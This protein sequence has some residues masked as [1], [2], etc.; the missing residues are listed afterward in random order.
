MCFLFAALVL[1]QSDEALRPTWIDYSSH[2][3]VCTFVLFWSLHSKLREMP[4]HSKDTGESGCMMDFYERYWRP[5]GEVLVGMEREGME[6]DTGHLK[7]MEVKAREQQHNATEYFRKWAEQRVADA[8]FMNVASDSQIQQLLFAGAKK[9]RRIDMEPDEPDEY[10]PEERLFKVP[11]VEGVIEDGKKVAKKTRN[12]VLRGLGVTIP[13]EQYTTKGAPA[14]TQA[15]LAGLAGKIKFDLDQTFVES[16]DSDSEEE[17]EEEEGVGEGISDLGLDLSPDLALPLWEDSGAV[18]SD[19]TTVALDGDLDVDGGVASDLSEEQSQAPP[20][21]PPLPSPV[22]IAEATEEHV[23]MYGKAYGA[24]G[25]GEEGKEACRALSALV[26]VG[27]INSLLT[28][29]LLP[30]QGSDIRGPA[31]R[32]HCSLN[33]SGSPTMGSHDSRQA[34]GPSRSSHTIARA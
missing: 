28:N 12:I 15:V 32:V 30:L 1:G 21:P 20:P 33:I 24:F 26:E 34:L 22:S 6:L 10:V 18:P 19:P 17:G 5:F 25:G 14:V 11:N 16:E 23:S 8:H 9:K 4:W 7:E 2:D 13:V 3:A 31:Q 29:F 27:S